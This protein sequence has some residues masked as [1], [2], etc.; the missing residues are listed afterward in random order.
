MK[1]N[2]MLRIAIFSLVLG[3]GLSLSTTVQ[4]QETATTNVDE[5][6]SPPGGMEG[7]TQYMI[8][9]LTYPTAAREAGTQG[10]VVLTFV[11]TAEGKVEAVEVIRGIG[12]GCDE[13]AVRVITQSGTW[14]PAKKEGKAVA[15]RM[16]LPVNF[17]L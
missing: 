4:A 2:T 9:N 6:P 10:M 15:T 5:M 11:V 14:T 17:K 8:K 16:N 12:K 3:A 1:I 13:E 7:F